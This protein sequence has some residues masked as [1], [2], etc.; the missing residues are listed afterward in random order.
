MEFP[1]L[2]RRYWGRRFWVRGDAADSA[3]DKLQEIEDSAERGADALSDVF[4]GIIDG[5]RSAKEALPDLLKEIAR[6][7]LQKGLASLGTAGGGV[8]GFL[9]S[10]MSFASGGYTGDGRVNQVAGVVHK[11]EY[12]MDATTTRRIGVGNLEAMRAGQMPRVAPTGNQQVEIV[13]R[14]PEGF[15][16]EHFQQV[17]G[18]SLRVAETSISAHTRRQGDMRYLRGGQ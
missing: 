14:A 12:V 5:S 15:T 3:A 6:I 7:Q 11:G 17:Q 1:E 10:L 2:R 4:L 18:I 16:A 8:L 13:L 9:G